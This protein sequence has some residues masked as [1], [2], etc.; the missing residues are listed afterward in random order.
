M[1]PF[2]LL[3]LR[4]ETPKLRGRAR[5]AIN[6]SECVGKVTKLQYLQAAI[7]ASAHSSPVTSTTMVCPLR[8]ILVGVSAIIATIA[9]YQTFWAVDADDQK[10]F[11][12]K[13]RSQKQ[14]P[15]LTRIWS[16]FNGKYV[17]E[18]W[19][20]WRRGTRERSLSNP[21]AACDTPLKSE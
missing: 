19:G 6:Q 12:T 13:D 3:R 21:Q 5:R 11:G 2:S 10:R 7:P 4:Y 18:N 8:F 15:V 9:M 20:I 16:L 14:Q 17:Y 1:P